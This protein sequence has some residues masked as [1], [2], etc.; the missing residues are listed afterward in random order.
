MLCLSG[1]VHPWAPQQRVT[2]TQWRMTG[3]GTGPWILMAPACHLCGSYP[4]DGM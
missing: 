1:S 3:P 2:N 4:I